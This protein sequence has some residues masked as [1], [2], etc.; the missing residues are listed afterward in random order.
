MTTAELILEWVNKASPMA[1]I[2]GIAYASWWAQNLTRTT[3]DQGA[4]IIRN[5]D[6]VLKAV[7]TTAEIDRRVTI[8]EVEK[9]HMESRL[10]ELPL[11]KDEL[12]AIKML[13]AKQQG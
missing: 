1:I 12:T 11:I 6:A 8:V 2:A 4:A 9:K 7:E 5:Q 3:Q 13:L 10:D